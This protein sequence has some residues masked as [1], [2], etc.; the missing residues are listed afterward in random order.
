MSND[1][2]NVDYERD[3][4]RGEVSPMVRKKAKRSEERENSTSF[5]WHQ[6]EEEPPG[7]FS[8]FQ[9]YLDMGPAR[10]YAELAKVLY[11]KEDG[12]HHIIRTWG[13]K[14]EWVK[15]AE[16]W[17]RYVS[18][19]HIGQ[20]EA[21]VQDAQ[22]VA[23]RFLPRVVANLAQAAIGERQVGRTEMRAITDFMDRFGPAKQKSQ[24]AMTIKN[25]NVN[26][27]E[28]PKEQTRNLLDVEEAEFEDLGQQ[29]EN[30]IP[31]DLK[32]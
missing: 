2:T 29:A 1:G 20:M 21:A 28:L 13:K 24:Q 16:A 14:W 11:G 7:A 18:S 5:P 30:L 9:I 31:K 32:K 4:Y 26:I 25:Y 27:P 17:D 15:R 12:D 23:L 10:S 8:A 22:E 19:S 3:L 6:K